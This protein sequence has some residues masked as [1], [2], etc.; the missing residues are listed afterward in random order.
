MR[1]VVAYGPQE[2]ESIENKDEFFR[3]L[4]IEVEACKVNG[5]KL[6]VVGDLN[7]KLECV[8]EKITPLSSN[9]KYLEKIVRNSN[10]KVLNF[11]DKC[12]GKWTHVIRKSNQKSVIDYIIVDEEL[13]GMV[14]E[15][16][17][18]EEC[19]YTPFRRVTEND[20][21]RAQYSDHNTIITKFQIERSNTEKNCAKSDDKDI[22]KWITNAEGWE[23]FSEIT[24][25]VP[26]NINLVV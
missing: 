14:S 18:D 6:M 21:T 5:D 17:I 10:L 11:G 1:V 4:S 19:L 12:T 3:D 13:S 20:N 7:S 26:C 22:N 24:S 8:D 16:I 2:N 25:K 23:K 9:G 15:M